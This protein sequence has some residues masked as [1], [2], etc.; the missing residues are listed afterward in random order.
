L[1]LDA[2]ERIAVADTLD[3]YAAYRSMYMDED[4]LDV[5]QLQ[6]EYMFDPPEVLDAALAAHGAGIRAS[7]A[8]N[9]AAADPYYE[10]ADAVRKTGRFD[11]GDEDTRKYVTEAIDEWGF[12]SPRDAPEGLRR[13]ATAVMRTPV[14][15]PEDHRWETVTAKAPTQDE[16][17][18]QAKP[19][20]P[21][22]SR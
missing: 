3:K 9:A 16:I 4:P 11:L 14:V 5:S 15:E 2:A 19:L 8:E 6:T 17:A 1:E 13:V 20:S 7:N 10:L 21:G 12:E 22:I 18:L